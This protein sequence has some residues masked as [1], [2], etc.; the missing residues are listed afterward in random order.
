MYRLGAELR[1]SPFGRQLSTLRLW[2][3]VPSPGLGLS[4][5]VVACSLAKFR[6]FTGLA[7]A[8]KTTG[9]VGEDMRSRRTT[10][11]STR[12]AE[13]EGIFAGGDVVSARELGK[14]DGWEMLV[15]ELLALNRVPWSGEKV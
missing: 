1:R 4:S 10:T 11:K 14:L 3:K 13:W 5:R 15:Q 6:S 2:L 7:A 9:F 8:T 12:V